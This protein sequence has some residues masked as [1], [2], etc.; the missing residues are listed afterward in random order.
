MQVKLLVFRILDQ[1][2][3]KKSDDTPTQHWAGASV[4]SQAVKQPIVFLGEQEISGV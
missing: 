1:N 2:P 4:A 3:K